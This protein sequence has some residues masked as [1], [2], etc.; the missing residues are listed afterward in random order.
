[1]KAFKHD[2]DSMKESPLYLLETD[3]V[4][5]GPCDDSALLKTHEYFR[6]NDCELNEIVK[7]EIGNETI[8]DI[9]DDIDTNKTE[10]F[11]AD[12]EN[13]SVQ[14]DLT[15]GSLI[16]D[17]YLQY[18]FYE[19]KRYSCADHKTNNI[20]RFCIKNSKKLS[21]MLAVL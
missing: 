10:D 1:M 11:N 9:K 15:K 19:I 14:Y 20:V 6:I 21:K 2:N 18:N 16:T 13:E 3:L 4:D 5:T 8:I 12:S 7:D 17:H